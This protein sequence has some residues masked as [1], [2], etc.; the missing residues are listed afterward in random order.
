MEL[1]KISNKFRQIA[2]KT[3]QKPRFLGVKYVLN[4]FFAQKLIF[5]KSLAPKFFI[6]LP[7]IN[8]LGWAKGCRE[9]GII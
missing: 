1:K 7:I 3:C 8:N 2:P 9:L 6:N 4:Q 5:L